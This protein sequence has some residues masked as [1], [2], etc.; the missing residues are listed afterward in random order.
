MACE[1]QRELKWR[2]DA[3]QRHYSQENLEEWAKKTRA[4][5][6]KRTTESAQDK[7]RSLK[8]TI[9]TKPW[10]TTLLWL[11]DLSNGLR[12]IGLSFSTFKNPNDPEAN[13]VEKPYFL[14]ACTDQEQMQI[15]GFNFLRFGPH[16]LWAGMAADPLHRR[17]SDFTLALADA[18]LFSRA[19][20]SLVCLN[21]KHGPF[22]KAGF[23]KKM[24]EVAMELSTKREPQRSYPLSFL[25]FD[26]A[27]SSPP[28]LR[29]LRGKS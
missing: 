25:C 5:C 27:R 6:E 18:R 24:R 12:N 22:E 7:K 4:F 28:C 21:V 13:K 14:V 23:F 19:R 3:G 15:T 17:S 16:G 26:L 8:Y 20:F 9:Q 11:Q 1:A 10:I 2:G 29:R